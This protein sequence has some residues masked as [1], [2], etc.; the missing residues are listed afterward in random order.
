MT[1]DQLILFE[2]S[3]RLADVPILDRLRGAEVLLADPALGE[4]ERWAIL[5]LVVCPSIAAEVIDR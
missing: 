4:D 5:A 2:Q 3:R 1:A